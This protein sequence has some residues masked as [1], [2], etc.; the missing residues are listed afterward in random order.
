MGVGRS[1]GGSPRSRPPGPLAREPTGA[2]DES[3]ARPTTSAIWASIAPCRRRW[4]GRSNWRSSAISTGRSDDPGPPRMVVL[5]GWHRRAS[6]LRID[7]EGAAPGLCRTR[8]G[9]DVPAAP[10]AASTRGARPK[11]KRRRATVSCNFDTLGIMGRASPRSMDGTAE[12]PQ[13]AIVRGLSLGFLFALALGLPPDRIHESHLPPV[14]HPSLALIITSPG[15][16]PPVAPT[17]ARRGIDPPWRRGIE[18]PHRSTPR[19]WFATRRSRGLSTRRPDRFSSPPVTRQA[20]PPAPVL[21][22]GLARPSR[23]DRGADLPPA[24]SP[25]S[26]GELTHSEANRLSVPGAVVHR[27]GRPNPRRLLLNRLRTRRITP[28]PA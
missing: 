16:P 19:S 24:A 3:I 2:V 21:S 9:D 22:I 11:G 1:S 18:R 7:D 10:G 6:Y 26:D 5:G 15:L 20:A 25:I 4:P 12:L 8:P 13:F 23:M 27:R 14:S 17:P 28:R